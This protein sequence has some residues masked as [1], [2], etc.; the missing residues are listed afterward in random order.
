MASPVVVKLTCPLCGSVFRARTI[1]SNYYISGIESDLR[2]TGSIDEVRRYS[3]ASC[4]VC[5]Y[6]DYSW[7]FLAPDELPPG[8]RKKLEGILE[9]DSAAPGRAERGD[10]SS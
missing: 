4:Q 7:D 8:A 1:G 2:E 6:S 5:R 9:V 3:I 10:A